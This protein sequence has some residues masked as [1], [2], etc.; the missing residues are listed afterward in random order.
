MLCLCPGV[1]PRSQTE[2]N[3][4][5]VWFIDYPRWYAATSSYY[6]EVNSFE[7]EPYMMVFLTWAL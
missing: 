7:N 2:W 1:L 5:H 4:S 6:T 3:P